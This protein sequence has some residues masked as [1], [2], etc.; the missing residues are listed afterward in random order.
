MKQLM[1]LHALLQKESGELAKEALTTIRDNNVG[2]A[3]NMRKILDSWEI[4]KEWD[5]IATTTKNAWKKE[6]ENATEKR[7]QIMLSEECMIRQRGEE[8]CKMKTK[9]ILKI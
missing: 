9:S 7:N 5:V 8:K 6:V 4:D 3:K 1:Y 2:W